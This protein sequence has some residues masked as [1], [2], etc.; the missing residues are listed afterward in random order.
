MHAIA[1]IWDKRQ[2]TARNR[3]ISPNQP[4][5]PKEV[6]RSHGTNYIWIDIRSN[7]KTL[8]TKKK[9]LLEYRQAT[10]VLTRK[11]RARS[12]S[13]DVEESETIDTHDK[14]EKSKK[15]SEKDVDDEQ[16]E[17]PV[18]EEEQSKEEEEK[19]S[20]EEGDDDDSN[21]DGNDNDNDETEIKTHSETAA[22]QSDTKAGGRIRLVKP[23]TTRLKYK[24]TKSG[25]NELTKL[26]PGYTAEMRLH[27]PSLDRFRPAG[28]IQA[29][30][31]RAERTD[32]STKGFVVEAATRHTDAMQKTS[33][34]LLPTSYAA[35]YSSFKKGTKRAKDESA[36]KGWFNMQP[37]PMTEELKTDL[38]VIRNRTHLDP[39]KFYK[40]ADKQ[41]SIVQFGTVIE[42]AS[43]YYSSRLTKKQRRAN[44]TEEILA[45]PSTADYATNK[46]KKMSREKTA[47]EKQA[48]KRR[49]RGKR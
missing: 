8:E 35:A 21:D 33:T 20:E 46:F 4:S 32:A 9:L 24:T 23:T 3:A 7:K 27:T 47:R 11:Q 38:A 39:K 12:I 15:Q 48:K 17:L 14:N 43:E 29:L 28:G 49:G 34:G 22:S 30:E 36:G 5:P 18:Q 26:I 41:H 42:G 13:T 31:R 44:I 45:D 40:S 37:T 1:V 6:D 19:E 10:M 2:L 16:L 25:K